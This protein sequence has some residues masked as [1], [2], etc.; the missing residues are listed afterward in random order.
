MMNRARGRA[1]VDSLRARLG[2]IVARGDPELAKAFNNYVL[3][4]RDLE[5]NRTGVLGRVAK[6][7]KAEGLKPGPVVQATTWAFL[8]KVSDGEVPCPISCGACPHTAI[9]GHQEVIN[10]ARLK[11][12][13]FLKT[14]PETMKRMVESVLASGKSRV[15]LCGN[16][17]LKRP[18]IIG[19]H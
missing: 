18:I 15:H 13:A 6:A 10:A 4:I 12:T 5:D 19:L 16:A 1:A 9:V 7:I 3:T 2:R 8:R 11:D 17:R 14:V